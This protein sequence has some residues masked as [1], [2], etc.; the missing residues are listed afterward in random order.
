MIFFFFYLLVIAELVIYFTSNEIEN[1][2]W[3]TRS[4]EA[5]R[6]LLLFKSELFNRLLRMT[7][8]AE[9][10]RGGLYDKVSNELYNPTN[11]II[12]KKR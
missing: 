3:K 5:L 8:S 9:L 10:H 12:I 11:F 4:I 7:S 1:A 6:C 2:I